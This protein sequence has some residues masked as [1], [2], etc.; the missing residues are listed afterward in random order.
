MVLDFWSTSCGVCVADFPLLKETYAKY[1]DKGLVI[2]GVS[3]DEKLEPLQKMVA[4]KAVTWPHL[5]D[6]RGFDGPVA[7]LFNVRG[8]PTYYVVGRDGKIAASR[9]PGKKLSE[10]ITSVIHSGDSRNARGEQSNGDDE[11]HKF[12]QVVAAMNLKPGQIVVDIGAGRGVFTRRFAAAVGPDGQAIGLEIDPLMVKRMTADAGSNNIKNYEARLVLPDDPVLAQGSADV[13]FLSNTYH[14]LTD[15]VAY[16]TKVKGALRPGGRI[17]IVD[18]VKTD[19][20]AGNPS[21]PRFSKEEVIIELRRAGYRLA[22]ELD[23]LLP[24]QYFLEFVSGSNQPT[25]PGA[26]TSSRSGKVE[27]REEIVS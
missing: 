19:S 2:L 16:F 25:Q 26:V 10:A 4:E 1:K 5:F 20:N 18:Y 9:V 23:F 12:D 8:T 24:S 27:V 3:L 15:R 14:H 22:R 21:E 11:G 6:G 13:V 17:V 7:K